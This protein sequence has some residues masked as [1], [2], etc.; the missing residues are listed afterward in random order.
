MKYVKM[1]VYPEVRATEEYAE[2]ILYNDDIALPIYV[3]PAQGENIMNGVYGI[4]F[5]RPLTH[6]LFIQVINSLGGA[7]KK[8]VIDDLVEG[9]FM[10]KLYIERFHEGKGEEI[11]LDARPS[12]CIALALREGC[13]IY[14]SD[15]VLKEAG[16]SFDELEL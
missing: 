8:V 13:D 16:K 4:K 7:I 11:V 1:D 14:V 9:V 3:S 10:A 2:V 15:S 5:T 12:D 6:D